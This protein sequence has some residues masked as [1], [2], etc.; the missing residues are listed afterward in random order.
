MLFKEATTYVCVY[1]YIE[2]T[3]KK[4]NRF[5]S[6]F[7]FPPPSPFGVRILQPRVSLHL[8]DPLYLYRIPV[9]TIPA[10]SLLRDSRNPSS[11]NN[12][13][14]HRDISLYDKHSFLSLSLVRSATRTPVFTVFLLPPSRSVDRRFVEQ[15][16]NPI[17]LI[18]ISIS[19]HLSRI[20]REKPIFTDSRAIRRTEWVESFG[21]GW[22]R[23]IWPRK[24]REREERSEGRVREARFPRE[25]IKIFTSRFR[26]ERPREEEGNGVE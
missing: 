11:R 24:E 3:R 19:I 5:I 10:S 6:R 18:S 25:V 15:R 12:K 17:P 22:W 1:I 4:R 8:I 9:S 2:N 20:I 26:C 21:S 13:I 14:V 16:E 7:P 23:K